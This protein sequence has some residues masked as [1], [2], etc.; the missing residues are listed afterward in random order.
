MYASK[1]GIRLISVAFFY[2]CTSCKK[3]KIENP[4]SGIVG[5]SF[6]NDPCVDS[7]ISA[8]MCWDYFKAKQ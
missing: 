5:I 8:S 4:F 7:S 2:A 6:E 1:I 3:E